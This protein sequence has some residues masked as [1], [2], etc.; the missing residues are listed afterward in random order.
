MRSGIN[1]C[2]NKV[3]FCP[4]KRVIKLSFNRSID[5][6]IVILLKTKENS[7]LLSCFAIEY[8]KS[9]EQAIYNMRING[10]INYYK[11]IFFQPSSILFQF[12]MLN[13]RDSQLMAHRHHKVYHDINTI[14]WQQS[15]MSCVFMHCWLS[16]FNSWF[17]RKD[18]VY[19]TSI[20]NNNNVY[21]EWLCPI[22]IY[23]Y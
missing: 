22:L 11:Y 17:H 9:E 10:Q 16:D 5:Q 20:L 19:N 14:Q 18:H 3:W 23:I 1:R 8:I 12:S 2:N 6:L 15:T 4:N 21:K 13:A 7:N